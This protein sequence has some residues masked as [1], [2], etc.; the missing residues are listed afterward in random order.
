MIDGYVKLYRKSIDSRV[1]KNSELWKVWTWCLMKANHK[2]TWVKVKTGKGETE[3]KLLPGQFIFGRKTAAEELGIP[4]SSIR[5]RMEKL[6]N[7]QN[8]DMQTDT[9]YSIISIINWTTYQEEENKKDRRKDRQRTTK[10]Q[11]E[12]TDKNDK[13]DKN[14]YNE[15]FSTELMQRFL[16]HRKRKSPI[17]PDSYKY[18]YNKFK[19]WEKAGYS[20]EFVV[21]KMIERGW[22]GFEPEWIKENGKSKGLGFGTCP[23]CKCP[24]ID[25]LENGFCKDCNR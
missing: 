12:D 7:M 3:V 17:L 22:Q 25:L 9:H 14:I 1:F 15:F 24:N 4:E 11:P 21:N 23:K 6:K 2:E 19:T 13:N 18:F 10:G 5:N 8:L 20:N 16:N